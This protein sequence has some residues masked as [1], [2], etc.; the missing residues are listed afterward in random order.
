MRR[1]M[2]RFCC[3]PSIPI[4]KVSPLAATAVT[5]A[6]ALCMAFVAAPEVAAQGEVTLTPVKDNTIFEDSGDRS[7]G[8]G[9]F[10]FAGRIGTNAPGGP[11]NRRALLAF[12]VAE[13]VPAGA[14]IDSVRLHLVIAQASF[15]LNPQF[16]IHRLTRDWGEAGSDAGAP[17]GQGAQA[18]A[19]D[20]TWTHAVYDT[21]TWSQAGGDYESTA[22]STF[23]FGTSAGAV[24][25][26]SSEGLVADVQLWLDDPSSNFGW[27]LLG[28]ESQDHSAHKFH[29]REATTEN[30][31][32]RLTIYYTESTSA[33]REEV[34]A[35]L[36]L[37]GNFPNPFRGATT[38][39][40]ALERPQQVRL[41]VF[42]ITGR[43]ILA[44]D[45]GV[46]PVGSHLLDLSGDHLAAGSYYYCLDGSAS[47]RVC[48]AM[49]V[50]P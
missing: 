12:D 47:G 11:Y 13:A 48:A 3:P 34:P 25:V 5:V 22:S 8:A 32:P 24:E 35:T 6:A 18:E 42:D 39:R 23:L 27:I 21:E 28:D 46:L 29:S 50:L 26:A 33:R 17:G 38:I 16:A 41:Q 7:N 31:R 2:R 4:R 43:A 36:R 40:Y 15:A 19:G 37:D 1:S 30:N 20:A 10:I 14:R 44:E 45:R 49:T 9:E